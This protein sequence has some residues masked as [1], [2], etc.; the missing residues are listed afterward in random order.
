MNKAIQG[1]AD[2]VES[3]PAT[4]LD[5]PSWLARVSNSALS[6]L[7]SA[8]L[9]DGITAQRGISIDGDFPFGEKRIEDAQLTTSCEYRP[10]EVLTIS[11]QFRSFC[12]PFIPGDGQQDNNAL[13]G[14]EAWKGGLLCAA[15]CVL[16]ACRGWIQS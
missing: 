8:L 2:N 1:I 14:P 4:L 15:S 5:S 7:A 10:R 9:K 12:S 11:P 16:C 3:D 6:Q 13:A